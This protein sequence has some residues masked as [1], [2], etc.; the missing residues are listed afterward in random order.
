MSLNA[1]INVLIVFLN[2]NYDA[3]EGNMIHGISRKHGCLVKLLV[4]EP[5]HL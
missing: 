1:K 4:T 2:K 3:H 5:V